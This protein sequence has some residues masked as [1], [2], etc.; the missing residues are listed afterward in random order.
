MEQK[1]DERRKR[2]DS[3]MKRGEVIERG[4]TPPQ[5]I[6]PE[7]SGQIFLRIGMFNIPFEIVCCAVMQTTP[8]I[9]PQ[10]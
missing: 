4:G 3:S 8:S 1:E 5:K 7:L 6:S 10:T 9:Y 2:G